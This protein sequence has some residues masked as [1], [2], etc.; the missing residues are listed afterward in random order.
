MDDLIQRLKIFSENDFPVFEVSEYLKNYSL[1]N[2]DK[3]KYCYFENDIYTRNLVFRNDT[4]EVLL[5]CWGPGHEAPVHGHEGEKCWARVDQGQLKFR[6]YNLLSKKPLS[7]KFVDEIIGGDG[8]LDGPAD[9]HSVENIFD[10]EAISLH[11]YAKPYD[12]CVV[13]DLEQ[14]ITKRINLSYYSKFGEVC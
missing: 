13:Y 7:L 5:L 2:E 4:F 3:K 1:S 11:V 6:N 14:N 10:K 8:F 12:S 9:I